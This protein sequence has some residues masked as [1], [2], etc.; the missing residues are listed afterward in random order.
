MEY[1]INISRNIPFDDVDSIINMSQQGWKP[2]EIDSYMTMT[3]NVQKD[4]YVELDNKYQ[5]IYYVMSLLSL[6]DIE[7]HWA[8]SEKDALMKKEGKYYYL[9]KETNKEY[10]YNEKNGE[11][12]LIVKK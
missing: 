2:K 5:L 8:E 11:F 3:M 4:F 9:D 10:L 1:K 12:S 6:A 7:F